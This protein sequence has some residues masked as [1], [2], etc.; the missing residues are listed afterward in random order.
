MKEQVKIGCDIYDVV[1]E[2][3]PDEGG[4]VCRGL[5]ISSDRKIILSKSLT[6]VRLMETFLHECIHAIDDV[7]R[8]GLTEQQVNVLG[9]S[10]ISLIRDN[11]INFLK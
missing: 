10:L 7:Y 9:V 4:E 1:F 3:K 6:D 5:C 11:R 2:D 8:I